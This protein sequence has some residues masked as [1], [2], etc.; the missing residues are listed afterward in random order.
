MGCPSNSNWCVLNVIWLTG[1]WICV[2]VAIFA[3]QIM[4]T[5]KELVKVHGY[6]NLPIA[7]ILIGLV[8]DVIVCLVEFIMVDQKLDLEDEEPEFLYCVESVLRFGFYF[9]S[10]LRFSG[11]LSEKPDVSVLVYWIMFR[12]ILSSFMCCITKKIMD[13]ADRR[14]NA[15]KVVEPNVWILQKLA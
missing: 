12:L 13:D 7:L 11:M 4:R 8:F 14:I 1:Y 9:L 3:A 15:K 2:T 6:M 10:Y 5:E